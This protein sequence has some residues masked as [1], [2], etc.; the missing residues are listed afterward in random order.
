MPSPLFTRRAL[1]TGTLATLCG[2]RSWAAEPSPWC[3]AFAPDGKS[4]ASGWDDGLIRRWHVEDGTPLPT[5]RGHADA[6]FG[7]AF[8]T[9]GRLISCG[10]DTPQVRVWEVASGKTLRTLDPH[11]RWTWC[12][13]PSPDGKRLATC[14]GDSVVRLWEL[15][16][17][18]RLAELRGHRGTVKRLAWTPDGTRVVSVGDDTLVH[19]WDAATGADLHA[20]GG[21]TSWLEGTACGP[22]GLAVT[23]GGDGSVRAWDV[24]RGKPLRTFAGAVRDLSCI[25]LSGDGAWAATGDVG[26]AV[27]LWR[28]DTGAETARREVPSGVLDVQFSP[29]GQLLASAHRGGRLYLWASEGLRERFALRT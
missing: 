15:E 21:H 11:E 17:G 9:N 19:V 27:R 22:D 2:H 4:L 1:L 25:A 16:T 7:I 24:K 23:A 13:R 8:A 10:R 3:V 6:V 28:V 14:G 20:L 26:G 5:L 12:A 29:D 18:A